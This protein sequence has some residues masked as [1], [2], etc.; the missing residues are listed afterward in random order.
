[1][2]TLKD[3]GLFFKAIRIMYL[4]INTLIIT[5]AVGP[6]FLN[7]KVGFVLIGLNLGFPVR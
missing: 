5:S 7:Y 1:M 6:V 4:L 3:R 2:R